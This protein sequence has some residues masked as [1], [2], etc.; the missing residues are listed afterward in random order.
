MPTAGPPALR[1]LGRSRADLREPPLRREQEAE[2]REL[3]EPSSPSSRCSVDPSR[4]RSGMPRRPP[5]RN[6]TENPPTIRG[7]RSFICR[8]SRSRPACPP[9][10]TNPIWSA[11]GNST[12]RAAETQTPPADE[13]QP[14]RGV[15]DGEGRE[16]HRRD[17]NEP[18]SAGRPRDER[19]RGG[20]EDGDAR[21]RSRAATSLRM[22]RG[23][24]RSRG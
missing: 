5:R 14:G 20:A 19:G 10:N 1:G 4:A 13:D 17:A 18:R 23:R 24:A 11:I 15:E 8:T 21:C 6:P 9:M 22:R 16:A 3:R 7:N 2:E 12:R